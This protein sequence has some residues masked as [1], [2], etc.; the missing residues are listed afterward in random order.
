MLRLLSIRFSPAEGDAVSQQSSISW[1]D[2][3]WNPVRGCTKVSPGCA[4]CYAETFA[5]RF[6]GVKGHPYEQGFD[7]RL[8]PEKLREPLSWKKPRRVFVNSMS[9]LFQDGVPDAFIDQAFAVMALTPQHTYQVLTK[10][11]ERMRAY[12][13]DTRG[14]EGVISRV[15]AAGRAIPKGAWWNGEHTSWP[16]SNVWLGVSVE[17]QHFA[18]ER[19]PVLLQTPAAIRFISAEPLLEAIDLRRADLDWVIVGGESGPG[20][21][22]FD[23]EW[24]FSLVCQCSEAEIAC[25]VKQLGRYPFTVCASCDRKIGRGLLGGFVD[26]CGPSHTQ[27]IQDFC[28]IHASKGDVPDEWPKDLCVQQFPAS[29][30]AM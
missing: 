27:S 4:H 26:A 25:F 18:D 9:D 1:T 14:A 5:E 17:N 7:L 22:P 8:V 21:R 28:R 19:I 23:V 16:W 11:P 3:T 15:N 30:G 24:A 6:R 13:S 2:S 12:M 10:R 20:A 29:K